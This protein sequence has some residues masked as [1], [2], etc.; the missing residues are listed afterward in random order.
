MLAY[1]KISGVRIFTS[2]Y[3]TSSKKLYAANKEAARALVLDRVAHFSL[4]YQVQPRRIAIK[5][6]KSRWGSCSRKGNLNFSYKL[7]FL[8]PELRD[9]VVVHEL[10]HL[11]EFNHGPDFWKLVSEKV[12]NYK[13]CA[14]RLRD[15]HDVSLWNVAI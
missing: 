11:K 4:H 15:V 1:R 12:P 7:L 6:L 3:R 10:C 5:N 8:T 13:E 2:L 14:K 9:Y